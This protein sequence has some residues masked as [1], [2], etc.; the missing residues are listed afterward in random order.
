MPRHASIWL[1]SCPA[2]GAPLP[3]TPKSDFT[4]GLPTYEEQQMWR[5]AVHDFVA[6]EVKPKAREV[7]ETGEFNWEAT[8]RWERSACWG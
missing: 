7:D 6:R 4:N 1:E 8:R 5:E 3:K 2:C